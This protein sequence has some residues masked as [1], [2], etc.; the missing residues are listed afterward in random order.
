MKT[1]YDLLSSKAAAW[2]FTIIAIACRVVNILYSS[3][4]SRDKIF[5]AVQSKSLL[6]GDG[7]SVPKYFSPDITIPVADLTPM[8]PPGYP[9]LLAPFL[10]AFDYDLA[11]A[12]VAI[13]I[14]GSIAIVFLVRKIAIELRFPPAAV[15]LI[16]LIAGCFEYAFIAEALPTDVPAFAFFLGGFLLLLKT[17]KQENTQLPKLIV[18]SLLLF[19][20]CIFRYSYPPLSIAA[21]VGIL[22][23]G[24]YLKNK[25]LFKKGFVSLLTISLLLIAFF[26]F[27]KIQTGKT[28]FIVD[29]GRGF[30]PENMLHCAPVVPGSFINTFFTTSQL[31]SK[32]GLSLS[33]SLSLLEITNGLMIAICLILFFNLLFKKRFFRENDPFRLFLF[34]GFIVSAATFV[35]LAYLSAI[36]K[37]QIGYGHGWNYLNEPRYFVFVNFYI[38]IAFIG[39]LFLYNPLKKSLLEKIVALAFSLLLFIEIT[40]NLYFHSKV[41]AEPGKY[42][43]APYEEADYTWFTYTL[44]SMNRENPDSDFLIVAGSD[45]FFPLMAAYQGRKGIYNGPAIVKS[46]PSVKKK[47]I[48]LFALYDDELRPYDTFFKSQN[49]LLLNKIN[50]VNFYQLILLPE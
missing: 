41:A 39:W 23:I 14:I 31:I 24:W 45:D 9:I 10:K 30:Y 32:T 44:E 40:H 6:A 21:P 22:F 34:T 7:L 25:L 42:S 19:V 12:T 3:F 18:A 4:T 48:L 28:G 35:S 33:Q 46:L 38:Q 13:D 47:T 16:T 11:A 43:V 26:V 17:T 27:L 5:L 49:A 2:I 15:N 29:T 1:L 50:G 8:W 20:P 37:P 36:Y